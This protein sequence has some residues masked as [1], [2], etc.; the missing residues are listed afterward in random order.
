MTR[1]TDKPVARTLAVAGEEYLT[2]AAIVREAVKLRPP[3]LALLSRGDELQD[4][5]ILVSG[6][7]AES[8]RSSPVLAPCIL[9]SRLPAM[10]WLF[11]CRISAQAH[12]DPRVV[13]YTSD[14]FRRFEIAAQWPVPIICCKQAR[15]GSDER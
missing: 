11:G 1:G 4:V 15:R 7:S 14:I 2:V 6:R 9:L 10:N 5:L 3:K 13:S 8:R 12:R